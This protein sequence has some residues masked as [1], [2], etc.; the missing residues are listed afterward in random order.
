MDK[1]AI[2]SLYIAARLV[3]GWA[4][5]LIRTK[6]RRFFVISSS[7]YRRRPAAIVMA[8]C[9]PTSLPAPPQPCSVIVQHGWGGTDPALTKS[10]NPFVYRFRAP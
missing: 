1:Q 8:I 4:R 9:R 2:A 10:G 3:Q 7:D 6:I 5:Q